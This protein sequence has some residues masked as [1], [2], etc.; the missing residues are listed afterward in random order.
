MLRRRRRRLRRYYA[1]CRR[2]S[3]SRPNRFGPCC[4]WHSSHDEAVF[5]PYGSRGVP[6]CGALERHRTSCAV[7]GTMPE[8]LDI[9]QEHQ[10]KRAFDQEST[11]QSVSVWSI[12]VP[13]KPRLVLLTHPLTRVDQIW[14]D[15]ATIV[16]WRWSYHQD[17]PCGSCAIVVSEPFLFTVLFSGTSS[18]IFPISA[19]RFWRIT[20]IFSNPLHGFC[21]RY[22]IREIITTVD[23]RSA[24]SDEERIDC[25]GQKDHVWSF[26]RPDFEHNV[27][28]NDTMAA[29]LVDCV[30]HRYTRTILTSSKTRPGFRH[31][32]DKVISIIIGVVVVGA[33]IQSRKGGKL[34]ESAFLP[35][36]GASRRPTSENGKLTSHTNL[37]PPLPPCF[38]FGHC[39]YCFVIVVVIVGR[40]VVVVIVIGECA[41]TFRKRGRAR[42]RRPRCGTTPA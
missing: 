12:S 35:L 7:L 29:G 32:Y 8:L 38:F 1:A 3:G 9:E 40:G 30:S 17:S 31:G 23:C 39:C 21:S 5:Q 41:C 14:A 34:V 10:L 26:S 24:A 18:N 37:P 33:Y 6:V 19:R 22:P 25:A 11:G 42:S 16:Q 36:G 20:T 13:T 2:V 4:G 27:L 28:N 15:Y